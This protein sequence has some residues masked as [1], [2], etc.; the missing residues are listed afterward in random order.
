MN[1][2]ELTTVVHDARIEVDPALEGQHVRVII[3]T[4]DEESAEEDIADAKTS[5]S[6]RLGAFAIPGVK[7]EFLSRE[8][9]HARQ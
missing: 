5:T 1:A 3:L 8:E 4:Q 9:A 6:R 7:I 2:Y